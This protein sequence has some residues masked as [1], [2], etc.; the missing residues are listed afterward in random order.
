M[1]L[2]FIVLGGLL[3]VTGLN[4]SV[5][6]FFGAL[7]Q[8][9]IGP[10]GFLIWAGLLTAIWLV[11]EITGLRLPAR[12]LIILILFAYLVKNPTALTSAG[13]QLGNVKAPA[14]ASSIASGAAETVTGQ[15]ATPSA[16]G[17]GGASPSSAPS[18]GTGGGLGGAL[19]GLGSVLGI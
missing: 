14:A 19:G 15:T 9:L 4:N 8:D 11:G 10:G 3:I 5:G 2:A 13:Q 1:E 12:Y 17:T 16:G 7:E 6:A 18:Q